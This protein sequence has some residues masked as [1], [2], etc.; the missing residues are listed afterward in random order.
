MKPDFTPSP[1]Q[2]AVLEF[3]LHERGHAFVEAVAGAGK[4]STLTWL[5]EELQ[6]RYPR[7]IILAFNRHIKEEISGI[8]K[9]CGLSAECATI[10]ALGRRIL[11]STY[12]GKLPD[13][14]N[15][16]KY[17]QLC[18]NYLMEESFRT[19][20]AIVSQTLTTQ[21]ADLVNFARNTLTPLDERSLLSMVDHYDLQVDEEVWEILWRGVEVVIR[22]GAKQFQQTGDHDF[23][24]MVFLPTY[25][26]LSA[27]QFGLIMVDEA[28]DL[29]EA[30]RATVVLCAKSAR[31]LFVGDRRQAIMGFSGADTESVENIITKIGA[32][33][34]P[35]SICW[36]CPDSVTLLARQIVPQIE[37]AHRE[38]G[39]VQI[40]DEA[41][42][43]K[44]VR[45]GDMIL[46]R[47][48]APLVKY[49]LKFLR[50][51]KRAQ[52][53][54]KDLGTTFVSLLKKLSKRPGFGLVTLPKIL[55]TY[56][57][58][59]KAMLAHHEDADMLIDSMNDQ[60][61]TM[62]ALHEAY[63]VD[64]GEAATMPGFLLYL[65]AFFHDENEQNLITLSTIHRAKGLQRPHVYV[66]RPDLLPHPMAKKGWQREQE[67]NL[68][69]VA[70]TRAQH[71]LYFVDGKPA[72]LIL[73]GEER[74]AEAEL[75][76]LLMADLWAAVEAAPVIELPAAVEAT[77][78]A[79]VLTLPEPV[80]VA[81]APVAEAPIPEPATYEIMAPL[82][83]QE[84][85]PLPDFCPKCHHPLRAGRA[86]RAELP[87]GK[88]ER[89]SRR[90]ADA[91]RQRAPGAGPKTV[92]ADG[93]M[94]Q[95]FQLTLDPDIINALHALKERREITSASAL[96]ENLLAA[97]PPM[98]AE[99]QRQQGTPLAS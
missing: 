49:C 99:L 53:R 19:G 2:R 28:Q 63:V 18:Q 36:R 24:D 25:L 76:P 35:L 9:T 59:R 30:Q 13:K 80:V 77:P 33:V 7:I 55:E 66:L 98:A 51:G 58:E 67:D 26:K 54:G 57:Q 61:E 27:P 1:Y 85:E 12:K 68:L 91:E 50:E 90:K 23:G 22:E 74:P 72:Q 34:L 29:N 41:L 64:N 11:A 43:L 96:I 17:Y 70:I 69:Y 45:A 95:V 83:Q 84:Q 56:R 71:S 81:A 86:A 73:P 44:Q 6:S 52:V 40:A 48:T 8:I 92:R 3:L 32:K 46:C 88:V 65:D 4:T 93:V 75:L 78:V 16:K 39:S 82:Q 10:H 42:F 47:T 5:A 37:P 62:L 87:E 21:L 20:L 60:V 79:E 94:R 89:K 15:G 31:L 97:Y 38:P 14:A